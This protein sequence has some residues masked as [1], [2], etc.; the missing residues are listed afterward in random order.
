MR[1]VLFLFGQ[2]TDDDVEWLLAHGRS[3]AVA[4]GDVLIRQ[5]ASIDAVFILLAG[6]L[7]VWLAGR[8]EREIARLNAG[9]IVG[10]MSFLDARPPSA[11]VKGSEDSTVF[12]IP[13]A[14]LAAKLTTDT[15]FAARFYRALA[16]YLA[17]TVRERHRSLGYVGAADL[18][19]T[20]AAAED[21][22]DDELDP[23]VLDTVYLAGERFDR[24][25]KRVLG[26]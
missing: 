24:M 26:A 18:A 14:D 19:P 16:I 21:G 4:A 5:G 8:E 2:L 15:G 20:E 17:T 12:A 9:E 6:K 7:S 1:K 11:T 3:R 22:D 13:R 25:V 23:V 10:E